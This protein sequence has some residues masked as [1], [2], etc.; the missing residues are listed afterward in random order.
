[1]ASAPPVTACAEH[2]RREAVARCSVCGAPLCSECVVPTP[3]GIKCHRCTGTARP[4]IRRPSRRRAG[5]VAVVV[6]GLL[7]AGAAYG[8]LRDDGADG[9]R[10]AEEVAD[11][12]LTG[13]RRVRFDGVGGIDVSGT[14]TIPE[15]ATAGPVP[16]VLILPGFG[17][18]NRDGPIRAGAPDP[19][20]RD[21][22]QV[23]ADSGLASLRY[24]KRGTGQTPLSA[25]GPLR[26]DDLVGD[27]R[28]AVS[29]LSERTEIRG[30]PLAVVGH[31]EG[32]VV[33]L[34]LAAEDPRVKSVVLISAPGRPLV[35]VLSD[36]F[37]N[38]HGQPSAD[39]FR[40]VVEG[41]VA[42]GSLTSRDAMPAE[43]R[44]YFPEAHV[45]Y[46]RDLFSLDPVGEAARVKVPVLIVRGA[47]ATGVS[48]VD[49]DR[50][51]A[52]LGPGAQVLVGTPATRS[53][54]RRRRRPPPPPPSP[55]EAAGTTTRAP[56]PR[57]G[58]GAIRACWARSPP[59]WGPAWPRPEAGGPAA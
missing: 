18:T 30:G 41:L 23:L 9:G 3:V 5:A 26:F 58:S 36:D 47:R 48:A 38:T 21:L 44:D 25:N 35:D 11:R 51:A 24:D 19:L 31:E 37:R 10:A 17:P 20:Y 54:W 13:E 57:L 32:A 29:F 46:L 12:N 59:G 33:A 27:A 16:G 6:G 2:R 55:T 53:P 39:A 56:V 34:R 43:H 49:S 14:F 50:L 1:M 28:A 15:A 42:T 8:L 45:A 4:Q 7:V 40:G 52:A 22:S